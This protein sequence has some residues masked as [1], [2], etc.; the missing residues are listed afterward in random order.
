MVHPAYNSEQ[1]SSASAARAKRY[2]EPSSS[3]AA[4]GMHMSASKK[5]QHAT[6]SPSANN[7]GAGC[8]QDEALLLYTPP[9]ARA[10]AR[11][12]DAPACLTEKWF[13]TNSTELL[14]ACC[15]HDLNSAIRILEQ[16]APNSDGGQGGGHDQIRELVLAR[17]DF[18][19]SALH[20]A[21][22]HGEVEIVR[23]LLARGADVNGENN[24]GSSPLNLAAVAG[25][26]QVR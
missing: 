25:S 4:A 13:E 21:S 7:A 5:E 18:R 8:P 20:L 1:Q 15:N 2:P 16:R 17:D 19:D 6:S 11:S 22:S 10:S 3:S 26:E 24:L 9:P 12:G 14:E 23:L